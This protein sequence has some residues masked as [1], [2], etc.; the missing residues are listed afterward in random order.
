MLSIQFRAKQSPCWCDSLAQSRHMLSYIKVIQE[1]AM[2]SQGNILI[3]YGMAQHG[4]LAMPQWGKYTVTM[5]EPIFL[6]QKSVDA[7]G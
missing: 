6:E 3:G 2:W 4:K 1:K 5:K 7:K